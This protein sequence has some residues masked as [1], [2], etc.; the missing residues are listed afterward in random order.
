MNAQSYKYLNNLFPTDQSIED[1]IKW[2][3]TKVLPQNINY[4][5]F[6]D[7]YH[8]FALNKDGY[9][10][11]NKLTV[12]PKGEQREVMEAEFNSN[13]FT[14]TM[15][16]YKY[17]CEK[18]INIKRTDVQEFMNS[19]NIHNY[20]KKTR[21]TSKPII[22][23]YANQ[24][25]CIDL[26]DM[27]MFATKN[28]NINYILTC[29]DAFSRKTWLEKVKTKTSENVLAALKSI[30]SRAGI[31]CDAL[32]SDNGNEFVNADIENWC[33][34]K[35]IKAIQTRSYSPESNGICE[36]KNQEV[37]KIL[38]ILSV[39]KQSHEWIE[40]LDIVEN[41][42][43]DTYSSAIKTSPN[44]LWVA[45]KERDIERIIPGA[46]LIANKKLVATQ[47][48]Q[49]KQAQS[50]KA[51]RRTEEGL[52]VGDKVLL[53]M[54]SLFSNFRKEVKAG[55]SKLLAVKYF[56][57]AF[58]IDK[59]INP[60]KNLLERRKYVLVNSD[61]EELCKENKKLRYFYASEMQKVADGYV[62]T[63]DNAKA[64]SLCRIEESRGDVVY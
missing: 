57:E 23:K 59:I 33:R 46:N 36:R 32:M 26:I 41:A 63:M 31:A 45:N 61:D 12:V 20:T 25:W 30:V 44:Q 62:Q 3:K 28:R 27:S 11:L 56:P 35:N 47:M 18:Y 60:R 24:M 15:K 53:R 39:E 64:L 9:L 54:A 38:N 1:V 14:S 34:E 10:T 55:N 2:K 4:R 29:V 19:Q 13:V 48:N 37:R 16:F 7:K 22:S 5:R 43:N 8:A 50:V 21:R 51:Y 17:L 42:L 6:T 52:S 40:F 58:I 49:K